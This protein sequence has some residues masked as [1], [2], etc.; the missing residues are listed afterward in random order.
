MTLCFSTD[1]VIKLIPLLSKLYLSG[2]RINASVICS[3]LEFKEGLHKRRLNY[4]MFEVFSII[5]HI[6]MYDIQ[7][8]GLNSLALKFPQL[9]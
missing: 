6:T 4:K 8:Q 3:R 5:L 7:H 9:P 1:F 2:T